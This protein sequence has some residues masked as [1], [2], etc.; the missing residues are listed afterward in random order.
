MDPIVKFQ[1]GTESQYNNLQNKD[2]NTFYFT[3]TNVYLGNIKIS[4]ATDLNAALVRIGIN[5]D[6]IANIKNQIGIIANLTTTEKA[7]LVSAINEVDNAIKTLATTVESL[8]EPMVFKGSLGVNGTIQSLPVDGTAS[9]GDTYKVITD[10]TYDS[11]IAKNG[12]IFICQTKTS[13]LNAWILIPSG[14][15]PSGTVTNINA[16]IGL[17]TADGNPITSNGTIKVNLKNE[18]QSDL[19]SE[20]ITAVNNRQYAIN[21]DSNG[22]LSVNVPWINIEVD[23]S[24]NTESTNPVQNSVI[25]NNIN[26]INSTINELVDLILRPMNVYGFHINGNE[27]DPSSKVTY[28][29][30]AVGMTPA[31]MDYTNDIFDY[32]SWG[33]K[34]FITD[35]KPCILNQDGTVNTYLDK[36]DFTKDING[37][38][39]SIDETL[40][41]ANVMIEFP[42]IWYKVV[43]DSGDSS[44]ASVY[45]APTQIDDDFKDYAYIDYQGNHKNHFYMPAYNGSLIN[46]VMRSISGQTVSKSL[47]ATTELTYCQANGNGWYSEDAGSIM[48]IN[49]LLILMGKSTDTQSVFGQ[50]LTTG[51]SKGINNNFTTGVHNNKGMFYGTNNGTITDGNYGNSV[52][53]FGIENYW[54]FQWRRYAGDINDKGIRKIKLCYGIED[55]STVTTYNT[56]GNGYIDIGCTPNGTNGGYINQMKFTNS[57]MYSFTSSGTSSTYYCDGQWFNNAQSNYAFR[58]GSSAFGALC[59]AFCVTLNDAPGVARWDFGVALEYK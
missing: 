35:C 21:I 19:A 55:G 4:N 30:A 27:S 56:T 47:N 22:K 26:K 42:K 46:N 10:G 57:G 39:V 2:P 48:L 41:D 25:T 59:G 23:N 16:G 24:L 5:E 52:K 17:V 29:A 49:F 50:G 51:G 13:N 37:N 36:N 9:I 6:N 32:G 11:Q 44:S 34:W 20:A 28:L 1:L 54:G 31:H 14:D 8:P 3:T 18:T 38:S 12:D 40:I 58:G 7:N 43:P 53:I 15:E 33:D 45:I